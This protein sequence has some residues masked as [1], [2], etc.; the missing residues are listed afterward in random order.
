MC[1]NDIIAGMR[2]I[3]CT[4]NYTLPYGIFYRKHPTQTVR[5]FLKFIRKTYGEGNN[6]GIVPVL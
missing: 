4:W 5:G 2:I 6:Q 3:P 1:W